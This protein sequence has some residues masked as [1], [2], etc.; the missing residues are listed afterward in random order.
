VRRIV[1]AV[2]TAGDQPAVVDAAAQLAGDM[3]AAV[4]VVAV[5]DV[6]SQRFAPRQRESYLAEAAAAAD[7]VVLRLAEAGVEARRHVRSGR[8]VEEILAFADEQDADAIV[9][10]SS[11]RGRVAQALLGDVTLELVQ[12]SKRPVIVVAAPRGS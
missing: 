3:N 1:L 2:D 6:E 11:S 7:S 8:A 9:V 4:E 10:G 12:R 5:D